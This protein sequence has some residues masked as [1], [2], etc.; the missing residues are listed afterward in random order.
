MENR[1]V[2]AT[3]HLKRGKYAVRAKLDNGKYKQVATRET[4]E[5]AREIVQAIYNGTFKMKTIVGSVYQH[6]T[7]G[8][9]F[10]KF[11]NR[12]L[13][14]YA[15]KEEAEQVLENA[16]KGIFPTLRKQLGGKQNG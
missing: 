14:Y 16:N 12:T 13:G 3:F 10:P 15:T 8:R 5:E 9:W 6:K 11:R 4:M 2:E 1:I 7:T